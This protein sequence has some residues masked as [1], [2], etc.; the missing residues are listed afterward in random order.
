MAESTCFIPCKC[1]H[2][3]WH[4]QGSTCACV[5]L[6]IARSPWPSVTRLFGLFVY[7]N[8]TC[9]PK[10]WSDAVPFG[11]AGFPAVVHFGCG[12]MF[13]SVFD[14]ILSVFIHQEFNEI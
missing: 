10:C 6:K 13:Y 2:K 9:R 14:L 1:T 12:V 11:C 3:V 4:M 5:G 7:P 8:A